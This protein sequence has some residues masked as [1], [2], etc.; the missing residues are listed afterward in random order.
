MY[1]HRKPLGHSSSFAQHSCGVLSLR[2]EL[3]LLIRET[4][5]RY[6]EDVSEDS[7][8]PGHEARGMPTTLYVPRSVI[9]QAAMISFSLG[10]IR[11]CAL[12][13]V[14]ALQR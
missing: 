14:T 9:V 11:N 12:L 5:L 4:G 13:R 8:D 10:V 2:E 7:T 1:T 6:A 3:F